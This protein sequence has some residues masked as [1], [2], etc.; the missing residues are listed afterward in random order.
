[1][2]RPGEFSFT[3]REGLLKIRAST[4]FENEGSRWSL[5]DYMHISQG[6]GLLQERHG[7][8]RP[9]CYLH[10]NSTAGPGE[11]GEALTLFCALCLNPTLIQKQSRQPHTT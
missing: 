3:F 5:G 6:L 7:G 11:D 2:T 8:L 9:V 4:R 10:E 1:M